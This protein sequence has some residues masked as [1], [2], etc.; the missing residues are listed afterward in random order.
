MHT[1]GLR[2]R[3]IFK[4]ENSLFFHISDVEND[5]FTTARQEITCGSDDEG[6]N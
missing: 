2:S 4:H 1:N 3:A 5:L 6:E